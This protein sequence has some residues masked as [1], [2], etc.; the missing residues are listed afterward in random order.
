MRDRLV[1]RPA[2]A[3]LAERRAVIWIRAFLMMK[4]GGITPLA[5]SA[6][7]DAVS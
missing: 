2:S 7:L 4:S 5:A 6:R 3:G 1:V